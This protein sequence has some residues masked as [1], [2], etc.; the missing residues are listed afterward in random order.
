MAFRRVIVE[1]YSYPTEDPSKV[2]KA[3]L[4]LIPKAL[5]EAVEIR[6]ERLRGQFG[7]SIEKYSIIVKGRKRAT[8]IAEEIIRRIPKRDLRWLLERIDLH[9]DSGT[10]YIRVSKQKAFKGE[11]ELEEGGDVIK[12]VLE[13]YSKRAV[14]DLITREA[15]RD[16]AR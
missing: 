13:S 4:S 14:I 9:M 15:T 12:V 1:T 2:K 3:L 8:E 6:S 7:Y 10:L 16:E 5:R 11:I